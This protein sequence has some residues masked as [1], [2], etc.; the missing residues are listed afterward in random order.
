[1]ALS[2][3]QGFAH[4][5]AVG[6]ILRGWALVEREQG[7]EG[8]SQM[9]QGLAALRGIGAELARPYYLALLAEAYGKGG[10]A[11]ALELRAAMSLARLWQR[12]GKRIEARELLA[13]V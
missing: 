11:A 1:M 2:V 7:K 8:M 12:Q 13:P 9:H 4:P 10:Q 5:L 3:E 6:T